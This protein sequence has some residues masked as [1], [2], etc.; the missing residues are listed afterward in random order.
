MA[1]RVGRP[2]LPY[3]VKHVTINMKQEHY[4]R[5]RRDDI[6]MSKLINDFLDD[7]FGFTICPKCY[8]DDIQVVTC[9]KCGGRA[10]FCKSLG[11]LTQGNAQRRECKPSAHWPYAACSAEEF[12]GPDHDL[13]GW[14]E[15]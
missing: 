5:M 1:P 2:P 6:N 15:G 4:V 12:Y 9:A 14:D 3:N 10:L 7:R 8:S 13:L 11:C